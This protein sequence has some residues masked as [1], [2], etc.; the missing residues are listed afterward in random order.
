MLFDLSKFF[1]CWFE[2]WYLLSVASIVFGD[3]SGW[4]DY[5]STKSNRQVTM[6]VRLGLWKL[7]LASKY[8]QEIL[9][10]AIA[11]QVGVHHVLEALELNQLVTSIHILFIELFFANLHNLSLC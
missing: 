6:T 8:P 5:R 2:F 9:F 1:I 11:P 3:E 7:H 10:S 4:K